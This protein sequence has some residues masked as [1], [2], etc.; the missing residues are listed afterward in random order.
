MTAGLYAG[1]AGCVAA[2]ALTFVVP[3][4]RF[5]TVWLRLM[6]IATTLGAYDSS[7]Q[8]ESA[9]HP[10]TGIRPRPPERGHVRPALGGWANGLPRCWVI[11]GKIVPPEDKFDRFEREAEHYTDLAWTLTRRRRGRSLL[12]AQAPLLPEVPA[13]PE[14]AFLAPWVLPVGETTTGPALWDVTKAYHLLVCAMTGYWKSSFA[15]WL[16]DYARR[17]RYWRVVHVDPEVDSPAAQLAKLAD[18]EREFDRRDPLVE[19]SSRVLV[20]ID[21]ARNVLRVPLKSSPHYETRRQIAAL[22]EDKL[23]DR[24]GK[25]GIH[26]VALTVDAR[27]QVIGGHV[28]SCFGA[29]M[30]GGLDDNEWP[31]VFGR[32]VPRPTA[33]PG[34]YWWQRAD[35]APLDEVRVHA[36]PYQR[37]A[38]SHPSY[39]DAQTTTVT[40][41]FGAIG[42]KKWR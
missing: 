20:I 30:A 32:D 15:L 13:Q 2:A 26:V 24:G 35:G 37:Q 7:R 25:R 19:P 40:R 3:L 33:G 22:V 36:I 23:L 38:N 5:V 31:L 34:A 12:L 28:R 4:V 29:S 6:T 1:L 17:S 10:R 14:P 16:A 41:I 42:A 9:S 27:A 11:Y 39:G 18:V 21:E 8:A